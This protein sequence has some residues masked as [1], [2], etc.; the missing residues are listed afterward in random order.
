MLKFSDEI[1][2]ITEEKPKTYSLQVKD[3][4]IQNFAKIIKLRVLDN[5]KNLNPFNELIISREISNLND[6]NLWFNFHW[7]P[8]LGASYCLK[9]KK[10]DKVWKSIPDQV[11]FK[12]SYI[13]EA[14]EVFTL[15]DLKLTVDTL[16]D[17]LVK[18][19]KENK[20]LILKKKK[21][22]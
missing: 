14:P 15:T 16:L 19:A 11:L 13:L 21:I 10:E 2:E 6:F 9:F 18:L 17:D 22:E 20:L 1:I 3:D 8:N 5:A 7:T 4:F 12:T